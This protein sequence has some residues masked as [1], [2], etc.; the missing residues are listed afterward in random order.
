MKINSASIFAF[1]ADLAIT[2]LMMPALSLAAGHIAP[3]GET[4]GHASQL[5]AWYDE[6]SISTTALASVDASF[7]QV[8][9]AST[10]TSVNIHVQI[11]ADAA[12]DATDLCREHDFNDTLTPTD[13]VVYVIGD[14]DSPI[15]GP[16][17]TAGDNLHNPIAIDVDGTR[18][19]IVVTA[20]DSVTLPRQAI[21]HNYLFGSM[22]IF[23]VS[24]D[25]PAPYAHST[26]S[27]GRVAVDIA[28][29]APAADGVVLDGVTNGLRLLQPSFLM[30]GFNDSTFD[31][32]TSDVISIA[33]SDTYSDPNGEY[34]AEPATAVWDP[35]M[36][37]QFE[38]GTSC[39][40]HVQTCFVSVAINDD[41]E[42]DMNNNSGDS[43]F[44]EPRLCPSV[45]PTGHFDSGW[46]KIAVSGISPLG[47]NLGVLGLDNGNL[48]GAS[49]M[50][51][52]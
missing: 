48:A 52:E 29:G 43:D 4:E 38:N 44:D 13:T 18:G 22:V 27:M 19:F 51:G 30:F 5:I 9:N 40:Q 17:P 8:T 10:D 25:V 50:V 23:E 35:F 45:S 37:D 1:V 42:T 31:E 21:S 36:F 12:D 34:R 24:I 6:S 49:W 15:L 39:Q 28:T 20:V 11:F 3:T 2:V 46:V 16:P 7:F 14:L 33:F 47:N 26:A 32:V 41:W